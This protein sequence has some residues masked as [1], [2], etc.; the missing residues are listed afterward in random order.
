MHGLMFLKMACITFNLKWEVKQCW[1]TGTY[2]FILYTNNKLITP[3]T[4]HT[5]GMTNVTWEAKWVLLKDT[6]STQLCMISNNEQKLTRTASKMA[7]RNWKTKT[8]YWVKWHLWESFTLFRKTNKHCYILLTHRRFEKHY[9]Q[10]MHETDLSWEGEKIPQQRRQTYL[11]PPYARGW[12][13]NY[14][15]ILELL[16]ATRKETWQSY[17]PLSWIISL[18]F[19]LLPYSQY[20]IV[21]QTYNGVCFNLIHSIIMIIPKYSNKSH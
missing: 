7:M 3:R 12:K 16:I 6:V 9:T 2:Y 8:N 17:H 10:D 18:T 15:V 14:L 11:I 1:A 4:A 5:G 20:S 13:K 21:K 19:S